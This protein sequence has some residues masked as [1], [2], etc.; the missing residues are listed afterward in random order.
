MQLNCKGRDVGKK[1][2]LPTFLLL[3]RHDGVAEREQ[4]EECVHLQDFQLHCLHQAVV[5]EHKLG[6]CQPV[7]G[8]IYLGSPLQKT[9]NENM[10]PKT[11]AVCPICQ[12]L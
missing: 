8:E 2:W 4:P 12:G 5:M 10:E 1:E 11:Y 7:E 9:T 6:V 3:L